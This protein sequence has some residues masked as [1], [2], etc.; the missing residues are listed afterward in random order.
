[1]IKFGKAMPHDI[2]ISATDNLGFSVTVGRAH[3]TF[4]SYEG[5]LAALT[6]YFKAP[7]AIIKEYRHNIETGSTEMIKCDPPW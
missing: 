4:T 6:A 7:Q 1:M 2:T 3:L 5:V